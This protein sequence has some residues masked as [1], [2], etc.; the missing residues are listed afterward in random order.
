MNLRNT[1]MVAVVGAVMGTSLSAQGTTL[2]FKIDDNDL[3]YTRNPGYTYEIVTVGVVDPNNFRL[4]ASNIVTTGTRPPGGVGYALFP[5]GVTVPTVFRWQDHRD[6]PNAVAARSEGN[7]NN[8]GSITL[9]N[10]T[11]GPLTAGTYQLVVAP[12]DGNGRRGDFLF[13]L[14]LTGGSF[15]VLAAPPAGSVFSGSVAG[16]SR[17]VVV[18]ASGVA[19]DAGAESL[20]VRDERL[21]FARTTGSDG[22]PVVTMS[23]MDSA[24]MMGNVYG[25]VELTGFYASDDDADR[26]LRG[27]GLQIGADVA[28]GPDMILGLSLGSSDITT[29]SAGT[30]I[31]GSLIYLQPYLAYR[32][33]AW[34]GTASLIYGQGEFD[35]TGVGGDGSGDTELY[36]LTFTGGYDIMLEPGLMATP[37]L[38][39]M[40]GREEVQGTGGAV[41]GT[42]SVDFYQVSL[43][44]RLTHSFEGGEVFGGLHA[45]YQDADSDTVLASDIIINDGFSA[46][47]EVGGSWD[48]GRG[49]AL[50][51]S[52]EFGGIGGSLNETSA[53]LRATFRF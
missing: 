39:L 7:A 29:D 24:G 21:S 18:D 20:F 14:T 32:S 3:A 9:R 1:A 33:G 19:R 40:Y 48:M 11:A 52:I 5:V 26:S 47:F 53:A 51:T 12:G 6:D 2:S 13:D 23:S 34:S 41:T 42:D 15:V 43:G 10:R 25:W 44:G 35:Q 50:D 46:R 8:R 49:L 36:A 45:D 17:L 28:L 4:D 27:H 31:D 30:V 16:A 22:E 37:M 38:G